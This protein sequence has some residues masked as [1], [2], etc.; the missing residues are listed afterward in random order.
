MKKSRETVQKCFPVFF[1][2]LAAYDLG[3][4]L[5]VIAPESAPPPQVWV[6]F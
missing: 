6:E 4:K 3:C 2:N 1:E 5:K